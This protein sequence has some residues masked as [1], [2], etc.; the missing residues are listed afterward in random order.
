MLL[1][2]HVDTCVLATVCRFTLLSYNEC[3]SRSN[4]NSLLETSAPAR[5]KSTFVQ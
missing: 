4:M 1:I 5:V 3:E 2:L